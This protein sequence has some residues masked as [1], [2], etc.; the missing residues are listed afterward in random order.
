MFGKNLKSHRVSRGMTQKDVAD[1][2]GVSPKTIG[3]WERDRTEP[4]YDMQVD[5]AKMFETTV[6]D[7]LGADSNGR[8]DLKQL[9][10][11][12]TMTYGGEEISERDL[13]VL[14]KVVESFLDED[15]D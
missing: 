1:K 13:K 3:S 10:K 8:V 5:L 15:D 11:S 7:L 14:A 4:S 9:L 6:Y 12:G 2:L